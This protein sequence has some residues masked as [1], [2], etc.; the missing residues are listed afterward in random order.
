MR[1]TIMT[2][3]QLRQQLASIPDAA[4]IVTPTSD[5]EYRPAHVDSTTALY[6]ATA[7]CWTEDHGED[8]TPEADYGKR[9]PVLVVS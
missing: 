5:H 9:V 1:Q 6:D 4:V 8:V 2:V 7:R 3:G